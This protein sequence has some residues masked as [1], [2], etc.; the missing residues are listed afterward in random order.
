MKEEFREAIEQLSW[1]VERHK[2]NK[3]R[4]E[5]IHKAQKLYNKRLEELIQSRNN[6]F[7]N[8][9]KRIYGLD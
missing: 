8:L 7:R 5:L 9:Y 4:L 2:T 6:T 1:C 3:E